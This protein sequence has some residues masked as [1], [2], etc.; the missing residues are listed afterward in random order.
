MNTRVRKHTH[1]EQAA[2]GI[3]F[4]KSN[5]LAAARRGA[6]ALAVT[7]LHHRGAGQLQVSPLRAKQSVRLTTG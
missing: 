3:A 2:D 6:T 7:P 4:A 1:H 5:N